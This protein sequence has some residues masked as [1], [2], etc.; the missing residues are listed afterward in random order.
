ML[1][2]S[3]SMTTASPETTLPRA[4][5]LSNGNLLFLLLIYVALIGT[6]RLLLFGS[7]GLDDAEQ[8]VLSQRLQLGYGTQPPLYTWLLWGFLQVFGV[9]LGTLVL[10]RELLFTTILVIAYLGAK[11]ASNN[12]N[13]ALLA[14]LSLLLYPQIVI[15]LHREASHTLLLTLSTALTFYL[16][17]LLI[18]RRSTGL[19]LLTGLAVALGMLSKYSFVVFIAGLLLTGLS[20]A[21]GRKA[22]F[23]WRILLTLG[24]AVLMLSPYLYWLFHSSPGGLD[25]VNQLVSHETARVA[26]EASLT[27]ILAGTVD[28]F[29]TYLA[30]LALMLII[31]GLSLLVRNP[32]ESQSPQQEIDPLALR[33]SLGL[34]GY[35]TLLFLTGVVALDATQFHT[36][37]MPPLLL[38]VPL[39]LLGL[40]QQRLTHKALKRLFAATFSLA[41][42]LPLLWFGMMLF[43]DRFQSY[44]RISAPFPRL[45]DA[46]SSEGFNGGDIVVNQ[47]WI[48]ANLLLQFPRSRVFT[49]A[50]GGN[51]A[52]QTLY[53]SE[54]GKMPA[55][56]L[57]RFSEQGHTTRS[58]A[59]NHGYSGNK[60]LHFDYLIQPKPEQ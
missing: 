34:L 12:R 45:A 36:H 26:G 30:V 27:G 37:W 15:D 6:S 54:S 50:P 2:R 11:A 38:T 41:L 53:I 19:Y 58:L 24:I 32:A 40:A 18:R 3:D 14:T 42:L 20:T 5:A 44:E 55:Y 13:I 29:R 56:L 46:L 23:D 33:L 59:L 31:Y 39:L 9:K 1:I 8:L 28:V 57:K 25:S 47:Y 16:A 17:V 4:T 52:S 51:R 35:Q 7:I 22:L 10:L 43:P 21:E 60:Q 48:G 49:S